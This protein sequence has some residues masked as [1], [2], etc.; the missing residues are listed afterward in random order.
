MKPKVATVRALGAHLARK[1]LRLVTT[2]VIIIA[3][4]II[5]AAALLAYNYTAW[6]W[7]LALPLLP[8]GLAYAIFYWLVCR[9]AAIIYRHP[10]SANQRQALDDFTEKIRSLLD[11][12][13]T[14]IPIFALITIKDILLHK[15]A[16]TIRKII[17]D[18]SSLRS[19]L[20]DLEKHFRE[21]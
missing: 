7:L 11:A 21:R 20:R 17:D 12:K 19:D 1:S 10:F 18:S 4:V 13:S 15:D 14:P 8:L 3:I 9:L 2:I 6:W 5:L 16:R